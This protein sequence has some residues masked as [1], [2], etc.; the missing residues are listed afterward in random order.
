MTETDGPTKSLTF[1]E[2]TELRRRTEAI[3]RFLQEQL[4][5][6][7]ETLRPILSPERVFGRYAGGKVESPLADRALAQLQQNYKPFVARPYDAPSELDAHWLALVGSRIAL[8]PWEYPYQVK[9]DRE[10]RA[11]DM[12]SPVRWV[13]SYTSGY[14]LTQLRH[15]LAGKGERRPEHVRQFIVN[16]LVTQLMVA[17]SPG[18]AALLADLRY[19]VQTEY[20]PDLPKLPLTTITA[21]V[22]SFRPADDLILAATGLSGVPAFIEVVDPGILSRLHDPLRARLE[23]LSR[24][25]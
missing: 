3:S 18:L 21:G 2:L 17:H 24:P 12:S 15:D 14:T 23:E 7:L 1:Q 25:T 13:M 10:T 22:A 6:H 9:T 11:I 19:H 5:T 4:L 8:Y 20:A 16:A